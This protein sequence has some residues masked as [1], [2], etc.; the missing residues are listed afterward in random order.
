MNAHEAAS[1]I[2]IQVFERLFVA[3]LAPLPPEV[4]D[5]RLPVLWGGFR[6][7]HSRYQR[8]SADLPWKGCIGVRP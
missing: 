4:T 7:V 5:L 3:H 1:A 6:T 2:S 8:T